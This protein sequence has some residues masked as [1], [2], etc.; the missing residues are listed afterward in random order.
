MLSKSESYTCLKWASDILQNDESLDSKTFQSDLINRIHVFQS[1]LLLK[2][3]CDFPLIVLIFEV[4]LNDIYRLTI[5][6]QWIWTFSFSLGTVIRSIGIYMLIKMILVFMARE[7]KQSSFLF[8]M[9]LSV[10]FFGYLSI[11]YI[12]NFME[13]IVFFSMPVLL[14]IFVVTILWGISFL[15]I[16]NQ[17]NR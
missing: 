7:I 2:E 15:W 5:G 1:D 6:G 9:G 3:F 11:Q 17:I 13:N 8:W 12:A 14:W 16:R 4:F 10:L